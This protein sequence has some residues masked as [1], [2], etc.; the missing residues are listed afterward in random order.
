MGRRGHGLFEQAGQ[1]LSW[2]RRPWGFLGGIATQLCLLQL[3]S[4]TGIAERRTY[5]V[6]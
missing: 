6:E 5:V 3:G 1:K 4:A 2:Q